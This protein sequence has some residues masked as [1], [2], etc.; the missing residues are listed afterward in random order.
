MHHYKDLRVFKQ[1][2]GDTLDPDRVTGSNG[3]AVFLPDGGAARAGCRKVCGGCRRG[4]ATPKRA[5]ESF[6]LRAAPR[7][8]SAAAKADH[9]VPPSPG[10]GQTLPVS[11]VTT[12]AVVEVAVVASATI[13]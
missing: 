2:Q 11:E 3:H 13:G 9:P 10:G 12:V 4:V 8:I 7:S 6:R 1:F 5:G